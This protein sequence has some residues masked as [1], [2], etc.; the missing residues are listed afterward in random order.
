V[1]E[2]PAKSSKGYFLGGL[3]TPQI[4]QKFF[5]SPPQFKIAK[6]MDYDSI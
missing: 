2:I 6:Q 5:I 4:S 1:A 3:A